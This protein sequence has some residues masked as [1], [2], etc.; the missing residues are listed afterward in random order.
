MRN[1]D[2]MTRL[3]AFDPELEV[4]ILIE[5]DED[6]YLEVTDITEDGVGA[7]EITAV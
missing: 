7:I 6:V 3:A 1:S 5:A 2:L 4:H